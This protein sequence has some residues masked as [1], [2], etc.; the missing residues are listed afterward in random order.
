[1]PQ[2]NK[3]RFLRFLGLCRRAG[4][5]VH[6]TPMICEALRA[7]KKPLLV[8]IAAD[9]SDTTYKKLAFKCEYYQVPVQR[10]EASTEEL[11]HAVGKTGVL[12][13]VAVMD[14]SF[15]KELI[16]INA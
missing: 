2:Q 16:R 1:M 13:A 4:K 9:V 10:T 3:E 8:I 12:A 15:A 6:G 14:E 11:A 5:T 7:R